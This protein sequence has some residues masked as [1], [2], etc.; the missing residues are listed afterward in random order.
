MLIA[1]N[2]ATEPLLGEFAPIPRMLITV[3]VVVLAMTYVVMP[4]MVKLF[5]RWLFPRARNVDADA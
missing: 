5:A 3:P 2:Y 4:G 1:T